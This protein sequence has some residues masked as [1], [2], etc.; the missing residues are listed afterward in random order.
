MERS[1]VIFFGVVLLTVLLSGCIAQVRT[2][3]AKN[4]EIL[5]IHVNNPHPGG[6]LEV[7]VTADAENVSVEIEDRGEVK[8]LTAE[9]NRGIFVLK[10]PVGEG[11]YKI[12]RVWA[13][14]QVCT[15][16]NV[17][18]AVE[19]FDSPNITL[20][21]VEKIPEEGKILVKLRV[22][23]YS[24]VKSVVLSQRAGTAELNGSGEIYTGVV[25]APQEPGEFLI[26]VEATDPYGRRSEKNFTLEWDERDAYVH[27]AAE[28]GVD[29][30][31]AL[32]LYNASPVLREAFRKD[33]GL[34]GIILR[35]AEE[36]GGTL[37]NNTAYKAL[38][39]M[40]GYYEVAVYFRILNATGT[41]TARAR[42]SWLSTTT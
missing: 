10:Y 39:L 28:K 34:T 4:P 38:S 8:N 17:G 24:G 33:K 12:L 11:V 5:S 25:I 16:K 35:I 22:T 29:T 7:R 15:V 6:F 31:L 27:F 3:T 26:T 9:K 21:K 36:S 40:T 13:C 20:E 18:E 30:G 14:S 23:D 37:E 2:S 42:C 41:F 19:V 32:E 1:K